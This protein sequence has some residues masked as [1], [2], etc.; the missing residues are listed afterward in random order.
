MFLVYSNISLSLIVLSILGISD[1]EFALSRIKSYHRLFKLCY[2]PPKKDKGYWVYVITF[3]GIRTLGQEIL[4]F[5][6]NK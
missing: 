6:N 5:S 1:N 2:Y 3:F 4:S